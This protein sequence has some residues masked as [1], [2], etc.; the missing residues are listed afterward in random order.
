[1]IFWVFSPFGS[2][3][4]EIYC[5]FGDLDLL[6]SLFELGVRDF[7][8]ELFWESLILSLRLTPFF[9]R[10]FP[11]RD[12]VFYLREGERLNDCWRGYYALTDFG[13]L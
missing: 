11:S 6:E 12:V 10:F 1:V 8:L 5:S 13:V 9:S 4:L 2:F 3:F 7:S